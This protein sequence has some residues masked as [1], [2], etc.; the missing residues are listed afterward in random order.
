M[1]FKE[2]HHQILI[3]LITWVLIIILPFIFFDK[4]EHDFPENATYLF[5]F[6]LVL[7]VSIFYV[8]YFFY[9]PYLLF[10]KRFFFY[11]IAI[12]TSIAFIVYSNIGIANFYLPADFVEGMKTQNITGKIVY[13]S[14]FLLGISTSIQVT[15]NWYKNEEQ[16]NIIKSEK[17]NSELSFLKSQVNPHFLFNTLNNIYSLANRK[18][19]HTPDAIMKLSHLMRYMLDEAKK[20]T[21]SLQNE[22]NYLTDYIELQKL[23][24]PDKSKVAFALDGNSSDKIIEPMLLIP[25]VENAFKH[26]DIFSDDAKIDILLRISENELYF[27]IENNID[28]K[29]ATEKDKVSG[30]GLNNLRKRLELLYPEKHY[31]I[32]KIKNDIFVSELKI[33]F[34]D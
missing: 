33:S 3:H 6:R 26:G 29:T 25:F 1:Q 10:R 18:S 27:K 15:Q 16:K 5:L 11:A 24:M 12:T 19:E 17:L 20:D 23:R 8:N 4:P 9:I 7:F 14:I 13:T 2:K 34:K 21:V 31:F 22:I 30:I 32:T 28:K